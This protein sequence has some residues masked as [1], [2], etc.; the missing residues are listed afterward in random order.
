[1]IDVNKE[2]QQNAIRMSWN[3]LPGNAVDLQRYIIPCGIHYTP[4]K[5]VDNLQLLEY[6]PVRCKTC[7]SILAPSFQIDFRSKSWT[8]P[9]CSTKNMFPQ[10]YA[11]HISEENLPVELF[12]TSTTIEYKLNKKESKHPVFF[13]Y[14]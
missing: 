4:L 11:Q 9:F 1:M 14:Y 5:K 6:E 3:I 12:P 2:E 10:A 8:C 7:K 13:F